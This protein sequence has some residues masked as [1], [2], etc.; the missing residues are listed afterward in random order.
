[1]ADLSHTIALA[2]AAGAVAGLGIAVV[3]GKK[4]TDAQHED[5]AVI[6]AIIALGGVAI[7]TL[8][9]LAFVTATLWR[10]WHG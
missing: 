7:I 6:N 4:A 2:S 9:G 1:M 10:I 5:G 3:G 8:S